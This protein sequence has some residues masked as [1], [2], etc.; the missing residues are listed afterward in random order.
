[1]DGHGFY[2]FANTAAHD[3]HE[4]A[5]LRLAPQKV[6]ADFL[7]WIK[8]GGQGRPPIVGTGGAA[9]ALAPGLH[10]WVQLN[11]AAGQYVAVW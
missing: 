8:H 6:A 7:A 3:T 10:S 1:M 4:L 5:I 2:R 11:L 9:G